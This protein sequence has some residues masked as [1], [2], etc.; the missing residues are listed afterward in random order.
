MGGDS[1]PRRVAC[2][3]NWHRRFQSSRMHRDIGASV[4]SSMARFQDLDLVA[5]EVDIDF[6]PRAR[7]KWQIT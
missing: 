4:M 7:W 3:E 2:T 1:A 6:Q 5:D